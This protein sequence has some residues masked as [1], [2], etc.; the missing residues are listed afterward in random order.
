LRFTRKISMG[1]GMVIT[2]AAGPISNVIM[3]I[4]CAVA[5]GLM[6]RWRVIDSQPAL[7][8][9][10]EK[11]MD[12]NVMLALFNLLPIPPLDGSRIVDGLIPYRYREQWEGMMSFLPYMLVAV[13]FLGGFL[14]R[15]PI[16]VVRHLLMRL[17][18][19]VAV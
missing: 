8:E 13:I 5:M 9:L 4:L 12:V 19:A 18:Y 6:I 11:T 16:A 10:L 17:I 3:A 15:G 7:L 2:A 14:L 1:Q